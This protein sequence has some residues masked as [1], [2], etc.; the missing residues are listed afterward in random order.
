M[1]TFDH[2]KSQ[3]LDEEIIQT[4]SSLLEKQ[5]HIIERTEKEAF[6]LKERE[7]LYELLMRVNE[8]RRVSY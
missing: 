7:I 2:E 3:K 1:I 6:L 5:K 4:L 8:E